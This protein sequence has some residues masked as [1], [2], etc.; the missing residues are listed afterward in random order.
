MLGIYF[1][2]TSGGGKHFWETAQKGYLWANRLRSCPLPPALAWQSF[3]RQLQPGMMWGIATVVMSPQKILDQFQQVNFR[4]LPLLNVDCHI[5]LL[6]C[7][8]P[9]QYQGLGMTNYALVSLS[10]KLS[11]LQCNWGFDIAHLKAM[12]MGYESFMTE[13]GLFGNTM[14]YNYKS[15]SMLA[16]DNIGLRTYGNWYHIS[17]SV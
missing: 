17:M 10:L 1:G 14:D 3:T 8:I 9:D 2:P 4:C 13:I 15:H 5:D 11:F 12:M 7:I 16:T 6:W